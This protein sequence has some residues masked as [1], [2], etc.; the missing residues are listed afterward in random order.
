MSRPS[1]DEEE[2]D[3]LESGVIWK[4]RGSSNRPAASS[5]QRWITGKDL[6]GGCGRKEAQ[7]GGG[8]GNR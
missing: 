3:G 2:M 6:I 7:T 4:R 5:R 1:P 8:E